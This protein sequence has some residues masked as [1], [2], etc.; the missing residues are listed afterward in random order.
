MLDFKPIE[1]AIAFKEGIGWNINDVKVKVIATPGH[2]LGHPCFEIF[3]EGEPE[4]LIF[5]AT[6]L[7]LDRFGP[8]FVFP[9]C[10]LLLY[11]ESIKKAFHLALNAK[12]I[13]SRHVNEI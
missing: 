10:D 2:S 3:K 5:F 7:G 13:A 8:R 9:N 12:V 1:S 11:Q 6:D 4:P